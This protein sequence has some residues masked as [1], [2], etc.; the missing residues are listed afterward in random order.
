MP[1][2]FRCARSL[3]PAAAALL[4]GACASV[5]SRISLPAPEALPNAV[6]EAPSRASAEFWDSLL[7]ADVIYIGERHEQ[8]ADHE[9]Q[10]EII[11]GLKQRGVDFAIGWE[12][13]EHPMQPLLDEWFARR[14][15]TDALLTQ[16]EFQTTWGKTSP[17]YE[18]MLRWAQLASV[19]S[20]GLNAPRAMVKKVAKGERLEAPERRL[21]P[22]GFR[23]LE[24]GLENFATQ[25]GS[26]PGSGI[27]Y[28]LYYRAQ[29]LRDQSMAEQVLRA[30]RRLPQRKLVVFAGRGHVE[31]G[32][33]IPPYVRQKAPSLRQIILF[34]GENPVV[35]GGDQLVQA[36]R[37]GVGPTL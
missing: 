29:T 34:P 3:L 15:A 35:A 27:D 22:A 32:F 23:P 8:E 20:L 5:D 17:S 11:R 1:S 24:G 13:F 4:L 18:K 6:A 25:M 30:L 14:L 9:Y 37:A 10:F 16:T 7:A 28:T 2:P 36:A 19:P 26:H 31:N 12:M 33:G 21:Q